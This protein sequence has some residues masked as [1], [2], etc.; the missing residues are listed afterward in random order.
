MTLELVTKDLQHRIKVAYDLD[1]TP[2][3]LEVLTIEWFQLMA[4]AVLAVEMAYSKAQSGWTVD[5]LTGEVQQLLTTEQ[6]EARE[7]LQQAAKIAMQLLVN[8]YRKPTRPS[9]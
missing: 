8:R 4:E 3:Q 2:E 7:H 6:D 1:V 5:M 9:P